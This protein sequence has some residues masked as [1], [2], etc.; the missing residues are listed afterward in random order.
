MK[1]SEAKYFLAIAVPTVIIAICKFA[2]RIDISWVWV[3]SPVWIPFTEAFLA[4]LF[5]WTVKSDKGE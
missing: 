5:S 3:L 4:S 1:K 2:L